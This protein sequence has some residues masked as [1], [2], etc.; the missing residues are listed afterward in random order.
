MA[1]RTPGPAKEKKGHNSNKA[2]DLGSKELTEG[3]RRELFL[4]DLAS[5]QKSLAAKKTADADLRDVGKRIKADG[6]TLAQI[7]TAVA[8]EEPQGEDKVRQQVQDT[9]QAAV[10]SA[11][12]SGRSLKCFQSRRARLSLIAL[13]RKANARRWKTSLQSPTTIRT[14]KL[15]ADS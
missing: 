4:K 11:A 13:T 2:K 12:I 8:L 7:I 5:Y 6:F 3:E 9:M 1:K 15:I 14:P 10:G